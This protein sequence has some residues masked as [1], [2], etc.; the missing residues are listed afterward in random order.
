MG[1]EITGHSYRMIG[2]SAA[3][4]VLIILGT[5]L[6]S[7]LFVIAG[8]ICLGVVIMSIGLLP[9]RPGF[10]RE[11][12]K[13]QIFEG[14]TIKADVQINGKGSGNLEVYDR[15]SPGLELDSSSN[16]VLVSPGEVSFQ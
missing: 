1:T 3:S 9:R 15:I 14:D 12:E 6:S 16:R 13:E 11:L 7:Q 2:Y 10:S 4:F 5:V 8:V